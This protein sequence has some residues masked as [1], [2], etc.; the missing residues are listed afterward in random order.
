M[1]EHVM[2]FG[3]G[4]VVAVALI[5]STALV[6]FPIIYWVQDRR[7]RGLPLSVAGIAGAAIVGLLAVVMILLF[8]WLKP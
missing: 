4:P 6:A 7:R 8:M 3:I 1:I 5:A 2:A